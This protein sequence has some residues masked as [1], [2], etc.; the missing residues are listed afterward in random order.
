MLHWIHT[1]QRDPGPHRR[2]FHTTSSQPGYIPTRGGLHSRPGLKFDFSTLRSTQPRFTLVFREPTFIS[3]RGEFN[4]EL[5]T[6]DS[7]CTRCN[8]GRIFCNPCAHAHTQIT[9]PA[10]AMHR[11]RAVAV[12]VR[13][14]GRLRFSVYVTSTWLLQVLFRSNRS[15][16]CCLT[17]ICEDAEV[18]KTNPGNTGIC[19]RQ[20]GRYVCPTKAAPGLFTCTCTSTCKPTRV[21]SSAVD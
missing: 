17:C 18:A 11:K 13:P 19:S 12:H 1:H 4:P 20:G 2:A 10:C 7:H 14:N 5:S 6:S 9:N 3:T 8:P 21:H 15:F 16:F